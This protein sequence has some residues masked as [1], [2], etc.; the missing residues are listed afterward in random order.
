MDRQPNLFIVGAPK[1]GTTSLANWLG[2]HPQVYLSSVKEPHHYNRDSR[3]VLYPDRVDY[4]ALYRGSRAAHIYRLDAS[5]WY[6]YSRVAASKILDDCPAARFVVCVRN[7]VDMAFSLHG[8][9]L[10]RSAREHVRSFERAWALSDERLRGR[11]VSRRAIDPTHLAYTHVCRLGS[12]SALLL[13]TVP[14]SQV[15]FVVLDDIVCQHD[16]TVGELLRFL[17]LSGQDLTSIQKDNVR[18]ERW[19]LRLHHALTA[20]VS[21][22]RRTGLRNWRFGLGR[23]L[24][25][26]NSLSTLTALSPTMRATLTEYFEDE[27]K[28]M[29]RILGREYPSWL[30]PPKV[31]N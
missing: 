24:N 12:Q 8:S 6:L 30:H 5:P 27:I 20:A 31:S 7:P 25:R 13:D 19:S 4:L 29:W 17:S 2:R 22:K 11:V 26:W 10:N 16:D 28:L 3:R 9:L 1:C 14:C 18:L 23:M 21:V 15:H